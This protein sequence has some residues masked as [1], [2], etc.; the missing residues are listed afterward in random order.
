MHT[1]CLVHFISTVNGRSKKK[2][3]K[4]PITSST[5]SGHI[6]KL[7]QSIIHR[8]LWYRNSSIDIYGTGNEHFPAN[9]API[10]TRWQYL[11]PRYKLMCFFIFIVFLRTKHT[12]FKPGPMV[13]SSIMFTVDTSPFSVFQNER[14]VFCLFAPKRR[15][16][17]LHNGL[18]FNNCQQLGFVILSIV[19]AVT[20]S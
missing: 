11:Y 10:L 1:A 18:K 8:C 20:L 19:Y 5:S 17:I 4:K 9:E 7:K 6:T 12:S 14:V 2:K 15:H 3:E 16:D 13:P